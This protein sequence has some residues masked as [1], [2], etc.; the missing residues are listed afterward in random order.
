MSSIT[1]IASEGTIDKTI[2]GDALKTGSKVK[3]PTR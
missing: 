2:K 3:F 1:L